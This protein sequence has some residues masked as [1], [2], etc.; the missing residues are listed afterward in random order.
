[1]FSGVGITGLTLLSMNLCNSVELVDINPQAI[2]FA[3][4]NIEHNALQTKAI[5]V[6]SDLFNN[7]E[8]KRY[9][10]II[11]NPPRI[12]DYK[13]VEPS[14][15]LK[16]VDPNYS[17]HQRFIEELPNH[18]SENGV[19]VLLEDKVNLPFNVVSH[20]ICTNKKVICY[21][22]EPNILDSIYASMLAFFGRRDRRHDIL[23]LI[24]EL[25]EVFFISLYWH[26]HFYFLIMKLYNP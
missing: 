2:A 11:G 19:A 18:L 6:V 16:A 23:K 26:R 4:L 8:K 17:I 15:R 10:L 24:S 14:R 12:P 3:K 25:K 5:A 7:L 1:M 21:I 13:G 9:D 22:M 20:V